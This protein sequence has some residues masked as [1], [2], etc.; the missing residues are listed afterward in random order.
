MESSFIISKYDSH[1]RNIPL[2]YADV[3]IT[4]MPGIVAE[5][6]FITDR[7]IGQIFIIVLPAQMSQKDM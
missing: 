1:R 6:H 2:G 3:K 4:G 7:G 5:C